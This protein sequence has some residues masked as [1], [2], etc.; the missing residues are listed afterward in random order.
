M[1]PLSIEEIKS[2]YDITRAWRDLG[3]EGEPGN[4]V[5]SPFREDRHNSFSV[6]SNDHR[7]KDFSGHGRGGGDVVDFVA[8]G[9]RCNPPEAL[10]WL[11]ERIGGV[12]TA[13][14]APRPVS[15]SSGKVVSSAKKSLPRLRLGSNEDLEKLARLR[16]LTV[17][18]LSLA[19]DRGLLKFGEFAGSDAWAVTD[20]ASLAELRRMNGQAWSAYKSLP[21]RKAHCVAAEPGAK[22]RPVGIGSATHYASLLLVEGAPDAL[23]AHDIIHRSGFADQ[24]GVL[25]VLGGASRIE[26]AAAELLSG[27]HVRII[28]HV[29]AAGADACQ[30]W[31]LCLADAGAVVDRFDLSGLVRRDG[32]PVKDLNDA[33]LMPSQDIEPLIAEMLGGLEK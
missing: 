15:Y 18:G 3:L 8:E 29:D 27:H 2:L 22:S 23:A 6:Y 28:P 24:V 13:K 12:E 32:V 9:L 21:E 16:G 17:E 20:G 11:R 5:P 10:R 33:L 30:R 1:I 25:A 14:A 26:Q 4:C 31:S 19:Q 7:W